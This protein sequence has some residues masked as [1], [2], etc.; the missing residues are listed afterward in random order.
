MAINIKSIESIAKYSESCGVKSILQTKPV[1]LSKVNF[2]ELKVLKKDTFTLYKEPKKFNSQAERLKAYYESKGVPFLLP[3]Q[4]YS[5]KKI[6]DVVELFGKDIDNLIKNKQLNKKTTQTA[7]EKLVPEAKGRIKI[8]DFVDFE[9]DMRAMGHSEDSIKLHMT[10]TANT[11]LNAD[12]KNVT[13]YINFEKARGG[14]YGPLISKEKTVHEI[15]HALSNTFQN[16]LYADIYKNNIYK[17]NNQQNVFNN[18]FT[19][20]E[21]S[22]HSK[23]IDARQTEL[24][25]KNMLSMF[26]FN[27]IDDLNKNFEANLNKLIKDTKS[28]G[29]LNI[30]NSKKSW[31]QFFNYLKKHAKNEKDA[32]QS[33]KIFREVHK[34]LNTPINVEFY[35]MLYAEMEKFF[36]QKRIEANKLY[37]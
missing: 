25:Q 29:E 2:S 1:I 28:M 34:D 10:S 23:N 8:N 26:L 31:K 17:A 21:K 16:N 4:E 6:A 32:Y 15:T 20:F 37:Q 3:H 22:Y 33:T 14:G 9:K 27:S 19:Q 35:T 5:D 7:L 36:A 24:T 11:I 13:V 30:G 18:I 12:K